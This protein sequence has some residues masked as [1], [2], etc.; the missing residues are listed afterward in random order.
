MAR[1]FYRTLTAGQTIPFIDHRQIVCHLNG[2]GRTNLFADAA[3]DA[4]QL[5]LRASILA[6]CLIGAFDCHTVGT[7]MQANDL[8]RAFPHTGTTGDALILVYFR[9]TMF[10]EGNG[11]E[12]T[13]IYASAAADATIRAI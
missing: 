9:H 11:A 12:F 10:I 2:A 3:A 13:S 4:G 7:V 5:T 1:T 8:L 6:K